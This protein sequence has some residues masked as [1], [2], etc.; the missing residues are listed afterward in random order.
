MNFEYSLGGKWLELLKEITPGVT[1]AAVLRD[2]VLP[3]GTGQFAA[4]QAVAPSLGACRGRRS[5]G[6]VAMGLPGALTRVV[7]A[8]GRALLAFS[9][10]DFEL[11]RRVGVNDAKT[12]P[13]RGER[14]Q[15]AHRAA[16]LD[17]R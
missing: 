8:F 5:R 3:S 2:P 4:I 14:P 10:I 16:L 15:V 9:R 1:R 6:D 17:G 12:L 13:A 11:P 7:M